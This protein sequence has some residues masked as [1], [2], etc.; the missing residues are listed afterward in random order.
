MSKHQKVAFYEFVERLT[1]SSMYELVQRKELLLR[2]AEQIDLLSLPEQD[3]DEL[4]EEIRNLR[5]EVNIL[6]G[7]I[8][9]VEQLATAYLEALDEA[10][11]FDLVKHT[12]LEVAYAEWSKL[13]RAVQTYRKLKAIEEQLKT[14]EH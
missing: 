11:T 4:Y 10:Q 6:R 3:A 5:S 14:Y 12:E 8:G 13:E 9:L 7:Y 2:E 1:R